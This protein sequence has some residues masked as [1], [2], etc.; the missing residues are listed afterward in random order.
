MTFQSHLVRVL[1]AMRNILQSAANALA[2]TQQDSSDVSVIPFWKEAYYSLVMLGKILNQFHYLF[3]DRELEVQLTNLS[4]VLNKLFLFISVL[5]GYG[6]RFLLDLQIISMTFIH[7]LLNYS[8]IPVFGALTIFVCSK[9]ILLLLIS[10]NKDICCPNITMSLSWTYSLKLSVNFSL[11][12]DTILF[13][14]S[15]FVL[16]NI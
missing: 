16:C 9:F 3:L 5:E 14:S 4:V 13:T 1:P 15:V 10:T 7:H 12:F 2:S 11:K 6:C 8:F